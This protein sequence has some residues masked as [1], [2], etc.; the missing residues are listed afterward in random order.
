MEGPMRRL[1]I[2]ASVAAL[3]LIG[4][5]AFATTYLRY[6]FIAQS[7]LDGQFTGSFTGFFPT[8]PVTPTGPVTTTNITGANLP[9][10]VA[11]YAGDAYNCWAAKLRP[12]GGFQTPAED[13][14]EFP[15]YDDVELWYMPTPTTTAEECANGTGGC[16]T[17]AYVFQ[18]GAFNTPGYYL[19]SLR[20][21]DPSTGQVGLF[22]GQRGVLRV[23][24]V[25]ST[26][27][28]ST[29]VPEPGIWSLLI[30]GFAAMGAALRIQRRR[31]ARA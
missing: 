30:A 26:E 7:S 3:T 22:A 9:L 10:C 8:D 5:H 14:S 29:V 23:S 15:G 11:S 19:S 16:Q 25:T 13:Y 2:A 4:G 24:L 6:D 1:A 20:D 12:D 27:A 31:F 21:S 28:T 17:Y 18:S